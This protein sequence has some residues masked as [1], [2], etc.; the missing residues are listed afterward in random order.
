MGVR[1][2]LEEWTKWRAGC[3]RRR[4]CFDL[5][6]KREKL[7]LLLGLKKILLDIDRAIAIIRDTAE[8]SQVVPNLMEGFDIDEVQAEYVAEIRLRNIN[9]EHILKR[10]QETDELEQEI[11][12]LE[13]ILAN[14]GKI[15]NIIIGDAPPHSHCLRRSG[16]ALRRG[17]SD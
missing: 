1:Q 6:K 13:D 10:T 15:K 5:E 16:A 7:H 3:I 17:G 12:R 8:E 11:A 9:K 4:V 14:E 2:I